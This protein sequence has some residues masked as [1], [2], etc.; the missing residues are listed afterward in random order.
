M[1]YIISMNLVKWRWLLMLFSLVVVGLL[2]FGAR[3]ISFATDY[4]VWFSKDNPEF[5]DFLTIQDTYEK[6]DNVVFLITP[7]SGNV[8][9]RKTLESIEW[10][11]EKAWSIPYSTRVNSLSNFQHTYANGDDVVVKDLYSH[12]T[13]LTD[14]ELLTLKNIS[15]S[16]PLLLNKVISE[17]ALVTAV[18]VTINLPNN[19]ADGSPAVTAYS[20]DLIKQLKKLN[21]D[22]EMNLT[23]LVIMD[24]AFLEASMQDMSTLTLIMFLI[25]LFGLIILLR[26]FTG[27]FSILV[28]IILSI[29][30]TMGFSGWIG[31]KLTPVSAGSPT[32]VMTIVV[33][34]A[35]HILVT[36]FS[37]MRNGLHKREAIT[38]SLR[39]N[40]QPIML[41][42]LT[43]VI[44]FLSMHF[45]D[46]PPFHDLGNMV[47]VGVIISF[48]LSMAFLPWL[49]M[50][51]PVKVAL[52]DSNSSYMNKYSEYII[53]NNKKMLWSF[54]AVTLLFLAFIPFNV[55]N[56]NSWEYFDKTTDFRIDTDYASQYLTGPYYLEYSLSSNK[57]GGINEPEYLEKLDDF[58]NWLSVQPEVVHVDSITDILKRLNKNLHSDDSKWYR[59]P[60]SKELAAQYLL[61]YEMS[62]P[63]GLDVNNQINVDKSA[64]RVVTSLHTVS[65][66][67]MISFYQRTADWLKNNASSI[68]FNASSPQYM[69]SHITLRTVYQMIGGVTFALILISTLIIISLRSFKIGL[70]SLIPNLFPPAIA[71]GIWGLL[72]GEIGFGLAL[73]LGMTIG[74]IVDDTVH[75]LSKY[76]RARREKYLNAEDAIR[77]AMSNVGTALII[78]TV[79]LTVGFSVLTFSTFKM[80]FDL[81][82]ITAITIVVALI[83]DFVLLPSLLLRFDTYDYSQSDEPISTDAILMTNN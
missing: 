73:G 67:E 60:E 35:V 20:R 56:D 40:L 43:T 11:T 5:L 83:V 22:I 23:G 54:T 13:E 81:G 46:V 45:S 51:L 32:I 78:T 30:A 21:P 70:I 10:L 63:Y 72:I 48:I 68:K 62:L 24:N 4:E 75:F 77:Y 44:G 27:A 66:N 34:N 61:L 50:L 59:L 55:I 58:R 7:K 3:Y 64:T 80:N 39:V 31:V 65:N 52:S 69:F 53:R 6:S 16:E 12:A 76:L 19:S 74:I 47:A 57:I 9:T 42:T 37:C 82:F 18:N 49:L 36:M 71:L 26:S 38:E 28:V 25:I 79:V 8:F 15:L 29:I 17:K 14:E 33:A 1:M 41:A 2:M